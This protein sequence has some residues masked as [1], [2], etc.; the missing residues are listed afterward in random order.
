MKKA[1]IKKCISRLKRP[2]GFS[3]TE[4]LAAVIILLIASEGMAQGIAF[5][6]RN[7]T[8]QMRNSEARILFSTLRDTI[9]YE[10]RHGKIRHFTKEGSVYTVTDF[11]SEGRM[12]EGGLVYETFYTVDDANHAS[13][14]GYVRLGDAA[15]P[16][17]GKDLA[18][19]GIYTYDTAAQIKDNKV[20]YHKEDGKPSYYEYTLAVGYKSSS[21]FVKLLEETIQVLPS[22]K[23]DA[24]ENL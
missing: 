16:G 20:V 1:L 24:E 7:F 13:A 15:N 12:L 17:N 19:R 9:N 2:R 14:Y 23:G 11:Y 18:T 5:A 10:L 6:S 21:G 8:I 4:M 22:D 3:F